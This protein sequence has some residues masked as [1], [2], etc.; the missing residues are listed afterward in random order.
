MNATLI[1]ADLVVGAS[2]ALSGATLQSVLCNPL[3]EPYILGLVGGASLGVAVVF[4]LGLAA[5]SAFLIPVAAFLGAC[6]SLALV[7]LVS[8]LAARRLG[9][10]ALSGGTVIVAGFVAGSF[11]NSLQMLVLSY[12]T[13]EQS[14]AAMKW[15][16][17]DLQAVQVGPLAVSCV[18]LAVSLLVLMA[19]NRKLD[20]LV[21][22]EDVARSLGVDV[23][24]TQL[25][26]L[27]AAS[28]ATAI[29]VA[30]AGAVGFVGLI[31]PHV[32]RR[33]FG[34]GH[35][36]YLPVSALLGGVFLVLAQGVSHFLPG[37]VPLGVV[38]ALSGAPFF[39]WLLTRRG[40]A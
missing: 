32:V 38:C 15:V 39:L 33:L 8:V 23:R 4:S 40:R 1:A 2:L 29:S 6:L 37:S 34:A 21:L 27:G 22:G 24:R 18:A 28:L 14:A 25:L 9:R 10:R 19:L 7:C 12:A 16:W 3:A 20:T 30:L 26:A 31:I 35:R 36:V 11:T 5:V 13:P 17:G